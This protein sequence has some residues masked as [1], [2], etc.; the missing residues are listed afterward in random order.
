MDA[1]KR[2]GGDGERRGARVGGRGFDLRIGDCLAAAAPHLARE[3]LD[4]ALFAAAKAI[5]SGR[6]VRNPYLTVIDFSLPSTARRLWLFDL[7]NGELLR[8]ELVAH[9]K[10]TG[11]NR[12]TRFSNIDGSKQSSLGLFVTGETYY[13]EN[14]YSLRLHGLEPGVNDRA[15]ERLI[16]MH[17]AWYVSDDHVRKF[18][19]LGR[20]WGC[21]ALD[22]GVATEV[23]DTVKGGSFLFAYSDRGLESSALLEGYQSPGGGTAAE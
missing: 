18:G 13:G 10:N 15:L 19:R 23:I 11:D 20:S 7:A 22:E 3:V 16:V 4:R 5:A 6:E 2:T 12:A 21:P 1:R 9:G 14:G 8:K 17:G